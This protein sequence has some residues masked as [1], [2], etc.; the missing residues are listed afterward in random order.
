MLHLPGPDFIERVYQ[1][2][3]RPAKEEN[4]YV[5]QPLNGDHGSVQSV[6]EFWSLTKMRLPA[7]TGWA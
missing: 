4:R 5:S 3:D 2:T 7:T 6:T 1:A